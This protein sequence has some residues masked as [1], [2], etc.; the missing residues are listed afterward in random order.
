M[1]TVINAILGIIYRVEVCIYNMTGREL[2]MLR[3]VWAYERRTIQRALDRER[4][5][6]E[7][8]GL[9]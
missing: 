2:P 5:L 1:K 7:Y 4:F 3:K 8:A 9:I 6:R